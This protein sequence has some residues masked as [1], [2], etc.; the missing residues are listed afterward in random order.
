MA[1]HLHALTVG[2]PPVRL[3][4]YSVAGEETV[5]GCPE[6]DVVFDI[7]KAPRMLLNL[8][9]VCLTHGH[10]DHAAGIAYYFW[11]R[12]FQGN[13]GGNLLL[14][15]VLAGPVD[16]LLRDWAAV[17][18]HQAPFTLVPMK[19]GGRHEIRRDL[20][21][22]AFEV[23]HGRNVPALGYVVFEA[24]HKL[25]PELAAL[26]GPEIVAIKKTGQDVT[27]TSEVPV[28]AY[29]GDSEPFDLR[30]RRMV[31]EARVLIAECTFFDADHRSR[32]KAGFHTHLDQLPQ[33]L[34]TTSAQAVVLTHVTRRTGLKFAKGALRRLLSPADLARVHLL[35]DRPGL[36]PA[37]QPESPT[38]ESPK[39][40]EP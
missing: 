25:R 26:T 35:M 36:E 18:G 29:L 28:V 5:V 11:Q 19:P 15:E 32:A 4:G 1:E 3:A 12:D 2:Q 24:R 21:V 7:G 14:P 8:T 30:T 34:G 33:L 22:E 16:R 20:F 17:E 9:N 6:L 38:G 37:D 39:A 13:P 31:S 40:T 10:M 27:V 23:A